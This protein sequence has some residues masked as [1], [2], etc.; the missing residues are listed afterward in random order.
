MEIYSNPPNI[1]IGE[2]NP[3]PEVGKVYKSEVAYSEWEDNLK[4]HGISEVVIE[5]VRSYLSAV[6]DI[7]EPHEPLPDPFEDEF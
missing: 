4:K 3:W 2:K 7:D 5:K 1:T 6:A